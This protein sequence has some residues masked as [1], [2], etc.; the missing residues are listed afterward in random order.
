MKISWPW[1]NFVISSVKT[2]YLFYIFIFTRKRNITKK[3]QSVTKV[4]KY[5]YEDEYFYSYFYQVF[6]PI[7]TDTYI[8]YI[9]LFLYTF[10]E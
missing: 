3:Y 8:L 5:K 4:T 7:F 6:T 9:S 1:Y 10:K 2:S